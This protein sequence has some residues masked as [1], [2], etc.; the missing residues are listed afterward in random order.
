MNWGAVVWKS[1]KQDT[2]ADST[3]EAEYIV[4]SDAA[5]E[6]VWI[7]KFIAELGVVPSIVDPISLYCD[8][9]RAIAQDKEPRSHKKSKHVLKHYHLIRKIIGW[10]DV[11]IERVPI[12]Q[13]IADPL[14]KAL[15]Q[16]KFDQHVNA[17]GI[18]YMGDWL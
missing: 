14:T 6:A 5:K 9:N 11:K 16:G 15:Y 1:S 2:T 18:R 8:N 17:M 7:K 13:N 4:A 12:D 10:Q 3:T